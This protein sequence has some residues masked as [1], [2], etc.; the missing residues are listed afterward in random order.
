MAG[1]GDGKIVRGASPGHGTGG[2]G[3]ANAPRNLGIGDGRADWDFL[4]RLPHASLES[5]AAN[6]KGKIQANPRRLDE[7]DYPSHQGFVVTIGADEMRA[8]ESGLEGCARAYPDH[9][10]VGWLRYLSC[11]K[12]PKWRPDC[13]GQ[14]RT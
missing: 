12:R 10:R 7:P 13:S 5:S 14:P 9:L 1:N 11:S 2:R 6:I 4:E 3:Y 8:R